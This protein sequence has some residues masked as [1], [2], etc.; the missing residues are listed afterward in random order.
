MMLKIKKVRESPRKNEDKRGV[1][2]SYVGV[3]E[4]I[5]DETGG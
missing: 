3:L 4:Y 2:V 1:K 5:Q